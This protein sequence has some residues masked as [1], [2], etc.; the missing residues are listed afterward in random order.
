MEGTYLK[1]DL[2]LERLGDLTELICIEAQ[3]NGLDNDDPVLE[4][5]LLK[6][7][8]ALKRRDIK[9]ADVLN[10]GDG[11]DSGRHQALIIHRP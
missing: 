1:G 2:A 4:G 3:K 8:E 10:L 7:G 11:A 5:L 6:M 9:K